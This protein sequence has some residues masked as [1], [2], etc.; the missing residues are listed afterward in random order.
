MAQLTPLRF[1]LACAAVA[2]AA[3]VPMTPAAA[4]R[5]VVA[6]TCVDPG[7][8]P[9]QAPLPWAQTA[10]GPER[11]APFTTGEGIT[12][13][14]LDSG[15]DAKHPQLRNR[16]RSGYDAITGTDGADDDCLGTGTQVAGVIAALPANGSVFTGF[17]PDVRI[18]PIRVVAETTASGPVADPAVLAAGIDAAISAEAD[19]IAVSAVAYSD[20][21]ALRESVARAVAQGMTVVAAVGNRGEAADGNRT[22]YPAAYRD[23]IGVGA[24]DQTG[25]RWS[26]SQHGDYVDIVAPGAQVLTLQRGSGVTIVDGT[27]VACGF[28]AATVALMR[29]R[30]GADL[31]PA[32]VAD[33]LLATATPAATRR[34][35]GHGTVNPYA[36]VTNRISAAEPAA[37]PAPPPQ[38]FP[39]DDQAAHR[40]RTV[41]LAGAGVALLVAIAVIVATY[42]VPRG[43]RRFWRGTLAP[44]PPAATEPDEPAPPVT[45]FDTASRP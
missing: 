45:L 13:A 26:S 2:A 3:I 37:L 33:V 1:A 16:V 29:A 27:G 7:L 9:D 22:P 44:R 28:V 39:A 21:E 41:A 31:D 10:L 12:V 34:F 35:F 24:I 5:T 40:A 6:A 4:S 17:A 25:A 42:A 19:V 32:D 43:R 23:V 8:P 14:V 15:V 30:W 20:D 38:E 36:A 11:V 18:V